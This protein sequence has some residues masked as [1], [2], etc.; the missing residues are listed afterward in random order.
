M[1]RARKSALLSVLPIFTQ[2]PHFGVEADINE[3]ST[4]Y[5][6]ETI[7]DRALAATKLLP[8]IRIPA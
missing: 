7:P 8:R 6:F 1:P 5:R 2:A 4:L 3:S